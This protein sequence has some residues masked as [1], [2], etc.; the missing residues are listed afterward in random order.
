[1]VFSFS[2]TKQEDDKSEV[3]FNEKDCTLM[4]KYESYCS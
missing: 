2:N 4:P 3:G 1:M